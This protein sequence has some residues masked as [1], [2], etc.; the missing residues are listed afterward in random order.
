VGQPNGRV[1]AGRYRLTRKLASGAMGAVWL[2]HDEVLNR[3]IAAKQLLLPPGLADDEAERARQRALHE[4]R[5]AA[6]ISHANTVTIFDVADDFGEPVLIMEY[7]SCSTLA[8]KLAEQHTLPVAEV[9]RIGAAV[10]AALAAAHAKGVVH[11][12]VKPANILLSDGPDRQVKLTDFGIAYSSGDADGTGPLI[13][14]PAYLAPETLSGQDPTPAADVF[15]LGATLYR[16]VEGHL[17]YGELDNR[18]AV[19]HAAAAHQIVPP[20]RAGPLAPLLRAMLAEDPAQRPTM[21]EVHHRLRGIVAQAVS[22]AFAPTLPP[23][24]RPRRRSLRG[25]S[26]MRLLISGSAAAVAL[27]AIAAIFTVGFGPDPRESRNRATPAPDDRTAVVM[28]FYQA[29]P[30]D[31]D[32][33]WTLL[34]PRARATGRAEFDAYWNSIDAVTV[35]QPAKV[36]GD[37]VSIGIVVEHEGRP[38]FQRAELAVVPHNGRLL[39]DSINKT[40]KNSPG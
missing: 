33:A 30:N 29:L 35:V 8:H 37:T 28:R 9:A 2:A 15:S 36:D 21:R 11:R 1:I 3:T 18:T 16:A 38:S 27:V 20:E 7:L 32:A 34:T 5:I 10:A 12:D 6:R 25:R 13:G 22:Q 26:G 40:I 19:L 4:A 23:A 39:I 24:E 31:K 14:S 17:I